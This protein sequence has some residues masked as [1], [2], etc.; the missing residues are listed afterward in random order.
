MYKM[1]AHGMMSSWA[2]KAGNTVMEIQ[3]AVHKLKGQRQKLGVSSKRQQSSTWT[4]EKV[5]QGM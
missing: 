3:H 2:V 1:L 5:M 4:E